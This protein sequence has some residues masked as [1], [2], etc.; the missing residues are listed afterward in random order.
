MKSQI[1]LPYNQQKDNSN[2]QKK[3]ISTSHSQPKSQPLFL[4]HQSL[5][6][7]NKCAHKSTKEKKNEIKKFCKIFSKNK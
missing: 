6:L 5:Y 4:S 7:S 2:Y 3:V 1:L